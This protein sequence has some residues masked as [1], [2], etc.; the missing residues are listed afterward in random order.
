MSITLRNPPADPPLA[1]SPGAEPDLIRRGREA[2]RAVVALVAD[3]AAAEAEADAA[4]SAHDASADADYREK[5]GALDAR[6]ARLTENARISDEERRRGIVDAA[7]AGEGS[8]KGEFA[9]ASRRIAADFDSGRDKAR[10]DHQ[11][12]RAKT[13]ADFE[14]A[15]KAAAARFAAARKDPDEVGQIVGA[16]RGRLAAVHADY[17]HFGLAEATTAPVRGAYKPDDPFTKVYDRLQKLEPEVYLLEGLLIPRA[18]KG[19]RY[20]WLFVLIFAAAIVPAVLFADYEIGIPAALAVAVGGGFFLRSRLYALS[21]AQVAKIYYPTHQATVD[22]ESLALER[23]GAAQGALKREQADAAEARD[24]GL[25]RAKLDQSRAIA[26]AEAD[27]DERL[28]QINE[29]YAQRRVEIQTRQALDMRE[30]VDAHEKR[31]AELPVLFE[32]G[33]TRLDEKYGAHKAAVRD[34]HARARAALAAR[35]LD[36]MA[37]LQAERDA[38]AREVDA[39]GPRWDDPTWSDRAFPAGV[40]PVLRFGEVRVD[41]AKLPGGLPTDPALLVGV[42][43]AFDLPALAPFPDRANLL[44]EAPAAAR[45]VAVARLR[46][47][48]ARLLTTLPPGQVRFTIVDPVGIGRNFGAFMHLADFDDLLVT[49]QAWT[50]P[51]QIEERLAD[52]SGHMERVTQ[53]YLRDEYATIDEYNAAAGE[54]AEPYRVLVVADFPAAFDERSAARLA[55][56]VAAGVPCG[57][58]VLMARDTDR[59][60]PTGL[61][62][63]DFRH[64]ALALA[65]DGDRLDRPDPDFGPFPLDFDPPPAGEA[66]TR[67]IQRIGAA[68]RDARRVEVP[69][70]FIQPPPEAWWRG[71]SRGGID[72]PLG[73]AGANKRQ[74]LALGKGT[75][76]H[77]LVAGRTGSG[78]STL[79]HALIV[80]L[81]LTYGPDEV[82]L[83]LIDFKKGVEFKVYA[84]HHL[85]HA[86]VVA[87]ESE[88]EFGISVLQRLDAEMRSRADRFRE[89]G[90]QDVKGY[91]DATGTPPLP[92]IMLI[93][94]EFQE[95]FVEEDKLAQEAALLLDRL[96]RQGRAF[97]V[98]VHLGSQSLGGAYAL[99]RTTLGQFAVRIALQCSDADAHLIL[100]EH[101]GAAGLLSRPGEAIYNDQNGA[102][103]ANH[104]FQVVWLSDAA[105]EGYLKQIGDLARDRPPATPRTPIVF[106]GDARADLSRNSA[107]LAMLAAPT[108]PRSPRS[109]LAWL[110][111]PV[112]IKDPTAATL[113]RQGGSHLLVVGQNAEGA[114]GILAASL[115]GLA[116]QFPLP[117][118]GPSRDGARFAVL[119]GTPEDD[120]Q[121]GLLARVAGLLPHP[122]DLAVGTGRDAAR[123]VAEV[124]AE[125]ARRQEPDADD[126]PELFLLIHD[127]GRFRDLRRREDDFGFGKPAE[128][129]NPSDHLLAILR[130]GSPLGVHVLTWADNLANLNRAFDNQ[131]LREFESRVLFQMSPNDSAHLLDAPH[132]AKLGANRAYFSSE[133]QNRLEK[134]RPYALPTDGWLD[135][136]R[137]QFA[138]RGVEPPGRQDRAGKAEEEA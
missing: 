107:L 51:R 117:G 6:Y 112:A 5:R 72:I 98:H 109:A 123:V 44:V 85:P 54:V 60:L 126:G 41:L 120:P 88:R 2:L 102:T 89:A 105:R 136:V 77:V 57:V 138:K 17:A 113:R 91:R 114:L 128:E 65:W 53:R 92:R 95:F 131:G 73:K 108:W 19:R 11:K 118:P 59:P 29:I 61:A 45:G 94:D 119:D 63:D 133:E 46:A 18:M 38:I 27:R 47:A 37:R 31:M 71:D 101:N 58:L 69:F 137:D 82:D 28:R 116:A 43:P 86:S 22:A 99:A 135:H 134:F 55:S 79:L 83:Y 24:E 93:V 34:H 104:F 125:V 32:A 52:L 62:P 10:S 9:K 84:A 3:R 76:Q 50:E 23:L 78:K 100:G 97:G 90:V 70:A 130:E 16:I 8:A 75:A 127:L 129:A 68:A 132:A 40:P 103:E 48:M 36:G 39:L 1:P 110:G 21:R 66:A 122:V 56:I 15:E 20:V 111:D 30:A 106:E 81:A 25:G 13:L 7:A 87:I 67:L 74:N 12:A 33:T 14:A 42:D 26:A 121:A 115:I 64:H 96:V 4:R 49:S 80:N 124:A 35:W